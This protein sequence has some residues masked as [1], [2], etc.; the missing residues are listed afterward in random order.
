M[1]ECIV[2]YHNGN[3]LKGILLVTGTSQGAGDCVGR[4][5][6]RRVLPPGAC[7]RGE[8]QVGR[9]EWEWSVLRE[10]GSKN[11]NI[12][13]LDPR[14]IAHINICIQIYI[15][16][17]PPNICI[18]IRGTWSGSWACRFPPSAIGPRPSSRRPRLGAKTQTIQRN[19]ACLPPH[20]FCFHQ[21]HGKSEE[22]QPG[23]FRIQGRLLESSASALTFRN[24]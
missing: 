11:S 5:H 22:V 2:H 3:M 14:S 6:L 23:K 10:L 16:I 4:L 1:H 19:F 9:V 12:L 18:H 7:E 13:P 8:V 20:I 21:N 15:D 24:I 17:F